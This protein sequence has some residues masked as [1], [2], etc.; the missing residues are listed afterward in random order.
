MHSGLRLKARRYSRGAA[1]AE[2]LYVLPLFFFLLF[3]VMEAAFIFRTRATL[4]VATFQAAR[5]GATQHAMV[6]PMRDR[7]ARGMV[8]LYMKGKTDPARYAVASLEST[9]LAQGVRAVRDPVRVI[10]PRLAVFE[11]FREQRSI[12]LAGGSPSKQMVIPNDNLKWRSPTPKIVAIDGENRELSIQDANLLKIATFW[13]HRLKVPVLDRIVHGVTSSG[14]GGLPNSAEQAA[15]NAY[16]FVRGG[17]YLA[18]TSHAVVRMQ[19]DV[20]L[21]NNN[22]N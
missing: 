7:L 8:P 19:S 20:V 18:I 6:E 15:C 1:L 22:L 13:C 12:R 11:A 14:L 3:G 16:G 9:A 2:L 5:L 4:N 17:F 21:R 10:S